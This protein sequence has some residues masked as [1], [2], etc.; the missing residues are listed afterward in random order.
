MT[1]K[2]TLLFIVFL[3]VKT[4]CYSHIKNVVHIKQYKCFVTL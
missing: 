2:S 4:D 3:L 1:N